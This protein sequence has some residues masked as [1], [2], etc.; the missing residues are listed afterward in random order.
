MLAHKIIE[1]GGPDKAGKG[2]GRG[3]TDRKP[4]DIELMAFHGNNFTFWTE[5]CHSL[6]LSHVQAL[7][8][9][10][11]SLCVWNS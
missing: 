4:T 2:V 11:F 1:V 9:F 8:A 7:V 5:V 6:N 10:V 3:K